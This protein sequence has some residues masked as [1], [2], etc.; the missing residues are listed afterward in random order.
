MGAFVQRSEPVRSATWDASPVHA[1]LD[2][3]YR[4]WDQH[5]VPLAHDDWLPLMTGDIEFEPTVW[6]RFGP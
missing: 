5:H 3:A 2:E 4:G 6:W 1:L